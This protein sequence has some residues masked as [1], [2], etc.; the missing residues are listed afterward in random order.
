MR[1][2]KNPSLTPSPRISLPPSSMPP[3]RLFLTPSLRWQPAVLR[4]PGAYP[5]SRN[6]CRITPRF[7]PFS[8]RVP[9][10]ASYSTLPFGPVAS[11]WACPSASRSSARSPSICHSLE[12][13]M[14][15]RCPGKHSEIKGKHSERVDRW[16]KPF[17]RYSFLFYDVDRSKN[18]QP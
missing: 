1:L 7:R 8:P 14:F 17:I 2:G 9:T 13:N 10:A 15:L 3:L 4:R 11:S 12:K 5:T 6:K 18:L 16:F